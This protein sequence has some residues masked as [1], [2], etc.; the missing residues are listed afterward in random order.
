MIRANISETK[1]RLSELLARVRRGETLVIMDRKRPVAKVEALDAPA[2]HEGLRPP[3]KTWNPASVLGLPLGGRLAP[4]ES[5]ARAVSE[6]RAEG[7]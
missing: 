2:F 1:N 3:Q 6:E 7:W 4:E 5:L